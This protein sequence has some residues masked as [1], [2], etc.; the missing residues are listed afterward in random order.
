MFTVNMS[1][2]FSNIFKNSNIPSK[3]LF[4]SLLLLNPGIAF[5]ALHNF[6]SMLLSSFHDIAYILQNVAV[7][8]SKLKYLI[9]QVKLSVL[10]NIIFKSKEVLCHITNKN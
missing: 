4:L 7:V 10:K 1:F 6:I 2:L 3:Q 8:V 5:Y 9:K